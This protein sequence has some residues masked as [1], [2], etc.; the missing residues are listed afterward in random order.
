MLFNDFFFLEQERT[1]HWLNEKQLMLKETNSTRVKKRTQLN[2]PTTIKHQKEQHIEKNSHNEKHGVNWTKETN[3]V[4]LKDQSHYNRRYSKNWTKDYWEPIA[5][6]TKR[7]KLKE[8]P[9]K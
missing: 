7:R 9:T 6:E 1:F 2:T 4:S 3:K 5:L 8:P